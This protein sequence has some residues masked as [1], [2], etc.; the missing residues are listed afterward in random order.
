MPRKTTQTTIAFV[1][2]RE[3][4]CSDEDVVLEA[5][6]YVSSFNSFCSSMESSAVYVH[7]KRKFNRNSPSDA[8]PVEK[9][10]TE[11]NSPDVTSPGDKDQVMAAL[12]L[13][14]G[15]KRNST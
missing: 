15:V 8:S 11:S 1:V 12:N 7:P 6:L 14:E 5:P 9:R 10:A 4:A 3:R 2:P 13:S